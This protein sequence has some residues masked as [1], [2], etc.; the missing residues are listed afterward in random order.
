MVSVIRLASSSAIS[1]GRR[2][3][4]DGKPVS[5]R[6]EQNASTSATLPT[7]TGCESIR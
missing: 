6:R 3:I 4:P 5:S 7:E 1:S 2:N